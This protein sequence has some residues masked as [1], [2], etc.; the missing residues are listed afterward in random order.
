M[1]PSHWS[2]TTANNDDLNLCSLVMVTMRTEKSKRLEIMAY[3]QEMLDP[4]TICAAH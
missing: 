1:K 3:D 2:G 4:T